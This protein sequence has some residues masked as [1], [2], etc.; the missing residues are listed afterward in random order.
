MHWEYLFAPVLVLVVVWTQFKKMAD[1]S[2][3]E[4][5]PTIGGPSLPW[6]SYLG[7]IRLLFDSCNVLQ[8]G[9]DQ[10]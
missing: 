7:A 4:H 10:V 8:K 6:F 5:I 2:D 1:Q 3:L 9:Y